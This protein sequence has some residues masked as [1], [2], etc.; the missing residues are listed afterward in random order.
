[1]SVWLTKVHNRDQDV[2]SRHGIRMWENPGFYGGRY[3]IQV[4]ILE[5]S[6]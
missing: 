1:M 5:I 3:P 2:G 4:T 6:R